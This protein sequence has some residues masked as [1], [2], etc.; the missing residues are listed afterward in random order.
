MLRTALAATL[1]ILF[2]ATASAQTEPPVLEITSG[3]LVYS[4]VDDGLRVTAKARHFRLEGGGTIFG[5]RFDPAQCECLPGQTYSLGAVLLGSDFGG[6]VTVDKTTYP[7]GMHSE[8]TAHGYVEFSGAWQAPVFDGRTERKVTG[9]FAFEGLV[10]LPFS[11]SDSGDTYLLTGSGR[12][13]L[14]LVWDGDEWLVQS[15]RYQFTR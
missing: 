9:A 3:S 7:L 11:G 8:E 2:C 1:S 13:T 6:V 15:A 4:D 12:A 5:G 10:V 14:H